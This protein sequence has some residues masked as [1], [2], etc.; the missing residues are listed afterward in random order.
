MHL[1]VRLSVQ[2]FKGTL[3]QAIPTEG[4][5]V[6]LAF[7]TYCA[8]VSLTIVM[9]SWLLL[10]NKA[11]LYRYDSVGWLSYQQ[12]L[13]AVNGCY[14]IVELV[15]WL[16]VFSRDDEAGALHS[17]GLGQALAAA[18]MCIAFLVGATYMFSQV[19]DRVKGDD[20]GVVARH[21]TVLAGAICLCTIVQ[22]G[23]SF[24]HDHTWSSD[25][26]SAAILF[27]AQALV[28]GLSI[29]VVQSL[30]AARA[31]DIMYSMVL[32][33]DSALGF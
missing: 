8:F 24:V 14:T 10:F 16:V 25:V 11:A 7:P 12:I 3:T 30:P 27:I 4:L 21:V 9:Y 33:E 5:F 23:F 1:R 2:Q 31:S 19:G 29:G 20:D 13:L 32:G 28:V 26:A 18:C 6:L 17:F 15:K 22:T